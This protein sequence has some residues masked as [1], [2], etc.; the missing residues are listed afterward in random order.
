MKLLPEGVAELDPNIRW[1]IATQLQI[2]KE[3]VLGSEVSDGRTP[4]MEEGWRRMGRA[5]VRQDKKA[6]DAAITGTT[7]APRC[8]RGGRTF[9]NKGSSPTSIS[10]PPGGRRNPALLD[11][12]RRP[13]S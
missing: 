6:E 10:G 2:I 8:G 13:F 7:C 9:P 11:S 3:I 4:T 5:V 12:R 1:V